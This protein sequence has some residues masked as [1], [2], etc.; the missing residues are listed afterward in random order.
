MRLACL[1]LLLLAAVAC[2][3]APENSASTSNQSPAPPTPGVGTGDRNEETCLIDNGV[4]TPAK[5]MPAVVLVTTNSESCTGTFVGTNAV[6]TASHCLDSAQVNGGPGA[7]GLSVVIGGQPIAVSKAFYPSK[8]GTRPP[9]IPDD[10]AILVLPGAVAP[11]VAKITT[12]PLQVGDQFTIA[13]FGALTADDQAGA[14]NSNQLLYTGTNQVLALADDLIYSYGE[15]GTANQS[16]AG[17]NAVASFGDSG[18]PLF[19]GDDLAGVESWGS[20]TLTAADVG[21]SPFATESGQPASIPQAALA[22]LQQEVQAGRKLATDYHVNLT[23]S[24]YQP[25]FQSVMG[26]GAE[27]EFDTAAPVA[28]HTQGLARATCAP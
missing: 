17:Q 13:G 22:K 11:G 18:G 23:W 7:N 26:Q 5:N 4:Q 6:L 9:P 14:T 2:N 15:S 20:P 24:K 19:V 3:A 25:W 27:I 12:T 16:Q 28:P 8:A 1:L 10:L 21:G